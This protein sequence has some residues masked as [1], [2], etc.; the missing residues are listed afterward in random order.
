MTRIPTPPRRVPLAFTLIELLVVIA[1]IAVLVGLLLPAVQKVRSAAART[2]STNNLKQLA[3]ACHGYH[4]A[5]KWLPFNG[6]NGSIAQ[7][8]TTSGSWAYQILPHI[9]Q[10]AMFDAQQSTTMPKDWNT[11]IKT[12]LCP[13]RGRPGYFTGSMGGADPNLGIEVGS[14]NGSTIT[15]PAGQTAATFPVPGG[16]NYTITVF[17]PVSYT[18][19]LTTGNHNGS[20][21]VTIDPITG[22]RSINFSGISSMN[23]QGVAISGNGATLTGPNP[24]EG[25]LTF[26]ITG[27]PVAVSGPSS[28]YGYNPRIND[29]QT[30][31][32]SVSAAHIK[33][34][35]SHIL[36]GTSN[37][38]L[39]GHIYIATTDYRTTTPRAR[40]LMPIFVGG[41]PATARA[42]DGSAAT[43]WLQDGTVTAIDQWGSAM[44]EGGLMAMAD[45]SV[46]LFPYSVPLTKFLNPKDGVNPPLP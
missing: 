42:G 32:T 30:S 10:Q 2:S 7:G 36:D 4:D 31:S 1:I 37:T 24:T 41:T 16:T 3:L 38:I 34:N 23:G 6:T 18:A 21:S 35:L 44:A 26:N 46:R 11:P 12:F 28:D 17:F 9:E 13:L 8:K 19:T 39:L 22:G 14:I 45:G 40:T 29:M 5:N 15:I 33:R 43:T 20:F 27:A 25:S